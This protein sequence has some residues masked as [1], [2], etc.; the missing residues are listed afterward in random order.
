MGGVA[1][2]LHVFYPDTFNGAWSYCPDSVDFRALQRINIYDDD[3]AYVEDGGERPS[4]RGPDGAIRF[5]I[6]HEIRMENVL[7]R[8]DS[9]TQSGRQW[10]AWNAVYGPRGDDGRPVPLWDPTT[11]LIDR[12]VAQ[13]WERYDLR[14]VL[15]HNWAT[16]APKLD[17]KLNVWIGEMD[18]YYLN[19]SVQPSRHLSAEP[20]PDVPRADRVRPRRGTLLGSALAG[21]AIERD[22]SSSRG[23]SHDLSSLVGLLEGFG[24]AH[25]DGAGCQAWRCVVSRRSARPPQ[26]VTARHGMVVASEPQAAAVGL[27]VLRLGGSAIDAAVATAFA[28]AVTYPRAGNLG[29]GGFIIYRPAI[30]EP[31]AYDFRETAPARASPE[32]FLVDGVYD[33]ERHHAS[34]VAVGVPGTV[35]RT[36]SGLV[37]ARPA[38]VATPRPASRRPRSRWLHHVAL[39]R[40]S[41]AAVLPQMAR[42]PASMSQYSNDGDPYQP[43]DRLRPSQ[44][45]RARSSALPIRAPRA[46]IA[47]VPLS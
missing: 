39:A 41:L 22:G 38:T 24:W 17:G 36:A 11:G 32:M 26:P 46:S 34:H 7:G 6:R 4:R 45:W 15:A 23:G 31:V 14:L 33:R 3:D 19:D 5:T 12:G 42:Y 44:T 9:W 30:G 43:G 13:H 16:L 29:G 37:R 40:D 2:A 47:A 10:G 8:G 28:L 35:A 27:E 20:R 18:D 21:R 25:D 1:L